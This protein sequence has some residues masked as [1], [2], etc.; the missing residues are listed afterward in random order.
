MRWGVLVV[1]SLL[2]GSWTNG[3][4]QVM[5]HYPL[6]S[7]DGRWIL[8]ESNRTGQSEIYVVSPTEHE[9]RRITHNDVADVN[10]GWTEDG[11]ILFASDSNG[12]WVQYSVAVDGSDPA[13]APARDSVL[14][15]SPH[16]SWLVFSSRREGSAT[17]YVGLRR[18]G[19]ARRLS[20]AG[21]VEQ[22]SFSPNGRWI[23]FE[24]RDDGMRGVHTSRIVVIP[25]G[26]S[27]RTVVAEGGTDP[28]WSPDGE[29]ILYK[30]WDP[31]A[32][33][34][35]IAVVSSSGGEATLLRP[36]AHPD[37][38]PDGAWIAF[39][40]LQGM[41]AHIAIMRPDGSQ[42]RCLTCTR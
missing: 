38:S 10:V 6:W 34:W 27:G 17:L 4:A 24:E 11:R 26:G 20:S 13:P 14:A 5:N 30:E 23:V 32:K 37:W 16:H 21:H 29:T 33:T 15:T 2:L 22:P 40:S 8:F 12:V 1:I 25:L 28:H 9:L 31:A 41:D 18:G 39:V 19:Q 7:P 36:G 3:G 42:L 35:I